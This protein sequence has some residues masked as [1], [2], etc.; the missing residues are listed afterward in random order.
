MQ[1]SNVR[2]AKTS[3]GQDNLARFQKH[4]D[5]KADQYVLPGGVLDRRVDQAEEAADRFVK[6]QRQALDNE[7][8]ELEAR[9]DALLEMQGQPGTPPNALQSNSQELAD[10]NTQMQVYDAA[11]DAIT[12]SG[13]NQ[14]NEV[15][16]ANRE[17]AR[18]IGRE[19]VFTEQALSAS[20]D[21]Y[22]REEIAQ[23]HIAARN[24]KLVGDPLDEKDKPGNTKK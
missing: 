2:Y 8:K 11:V 6:K 9:R 5:Y 3:M 17:T 20:P 15:H 13:M 21:E 18:A 24:A 7:M 4:E 16:R 23:K 19:R 10:I 14:V 22:H 12:K 1:Q